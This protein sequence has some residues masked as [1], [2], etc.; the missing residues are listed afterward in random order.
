MATKTINEQWS[1]DESETVSLDDM[2]YTVIRVKR[3]ITDD[4]EKALSVNSK[5]RRVDDIFQYCGSL[6]LNS[7][8]AKIKEITIGRK[9]TADSLKEKVVTSLT[10]I[11]NKLHSPKPERKKV[12]NTNDTSLIFDITHEEIKNK[13]QV[14]DISLNGAKLIREQLNIS[15][16]KKELDDYVYDIYYAPR[17]IALEPEDLVFEGHEVFTSYI[18]ETRPDWEE[19]DD[20]NDED[21]WRNDY[22]DTESDEFD[23]YDGDYYG[24]DRGD[25]AESRSSGDE[26]DFLDD[27]DNDDY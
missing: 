26:G 17:D 24:G 13:K 23:E 7:S 4:P 5:K 22:P 21:N 16:N 8:D 2:K 1:I 6:P 10:T 14:D 12:K 27:Y 15:E 11:E 25:Y 18:E 3:K 19:D 9:R 20:S